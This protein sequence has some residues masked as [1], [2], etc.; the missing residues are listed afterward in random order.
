M[1]N[2]GYE[3]RR[4]ALFARWKQAR[5][6]YQANGRCFA[7]DGIVDVEQWRKA[8]P[9]I[10]F[11][12]KETHCPPE[13]WEPHDGIASNANHFSRNIARWHSIVQALYTERAT[14]PSF[15]GSILPETITDIALVELKKVNEGRRKSNDNDIKA[16]ANRDVAF[17]REQIELIQPQLIFCCGTGDIYAD[18]L[19]ADEPL[20]EICRKWGA[21]GCFKHRNRLVI[22]FYHPSPRGYGHEQLFAML[23][24]LLQEGAVFEHF[25]WQGL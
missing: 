14:I 18:N 22:D 20:E 25:S 16:Y 13:E 6:E 11:L 4:D 12:L 23:L 9:K 24:E 5:P 8:K 3:E 15:T 1:K 19:Y 7:H 17:L 10:L 2:S 21:K